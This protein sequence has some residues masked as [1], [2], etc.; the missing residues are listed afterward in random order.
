M[1]FSAVVIASL[2]NSLVGASPVQLVKRD[3]ASL[4]GEYT[5]YHSTSITDPSQP[6]VVIT[7]TNSDPQD[8]SYITS[9]SQDDNTNV[10][11]ARYFHMKGTQDDSNMPGSLPN[12][13]E[14]CDDEED[15]VQPKDIQPPPATTPQPSYGPMPSQPK[16]PKQPKIPTTPTTPSNSNDPFQKQML[17]NHNRLRALHG[18]NP[19]TWNDDM[20]RV[21]TTNCEQC[22]MVHTQ[23]N[24][25]GENLA[26]GT[27]MN[28]DMATQMWYAEEKLFPWQQLASGDDIAF[29]PAWGHF[30]QMVWASATQL[31]CAQLKCGDGNTYI[32][33]EYTTGNVD[34]EYKE[35]V[36]PPLSGNTPTSPTT[37]TTPTY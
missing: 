32:A 21:S 23:G 19:L 29:D 25:Y 8:D 10:N 24:S 20:V 6:G 14:D 15:G 28:A 7:T 22:Q 13:Q 31:G 30:S 11:G 4:P 33:C 3:R 12:S 26:M 16:I 37:P 1:R 2:V 36:K 18:A 17:D 9:Y 27:N 5:P 34:G 35:N